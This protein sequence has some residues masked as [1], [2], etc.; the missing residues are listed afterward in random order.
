MLRRARPVL[1]VLGFLAL[2]IAY[3]VLYMVWRPG[4]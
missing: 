3:S 2:G 4:L 1:I